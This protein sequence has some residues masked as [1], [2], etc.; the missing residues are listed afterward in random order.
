M[1][2]PKVGP[3]RTFLIFILVSSCKMIA[4]YEK[5]YYGPGAGIRKVRCSN[6]AICR[7]LLTYPLKKSGPGGILSSR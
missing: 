2:S 3:R 6:Y 7:L 5:R 4:T 1:N